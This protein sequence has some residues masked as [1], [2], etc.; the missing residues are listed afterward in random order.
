MIAIGLVLASILG[1]SEISSC[2]MNPPPLAME[3]VKSSRDVK[4]FVVGSPQSMS[5]LLKD[6]TLIRVVSMGCVDSGS[7]ATIWVNNPPQPGDERA[8][9][10]LF[11]RLA[12]IAFDPAESK[13]FVAWIPKAK[14]TR[15]DKSVLSAGMSE[16]VDLSINV[17][18]MVDGMGDE[19]TMSF[20]YH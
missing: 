17:Q 13:S 11:I 3:A 5:I 18:P 14:F 1:G 19:I 9:R 7:T 20:T 10:E 6:G 4:N 8:W 16:N 15:T 12:S 2:P